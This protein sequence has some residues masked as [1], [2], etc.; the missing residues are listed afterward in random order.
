MPASAWKPE[1]GKRYVDHATEHVVSMPDG[2]LPFECALCDEP[3]DV[4]YAFRMLR[5]STFLGGFGS[6]IVRTRSKNAS[7]SLTLVYG[8]VGTFAIPGEDY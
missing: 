1:I 5:V 7:T 3:T 6:A 2:D 4:V 8:G